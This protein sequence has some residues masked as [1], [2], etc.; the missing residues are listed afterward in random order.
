MKILHLIDPDSVVG[1]VETLAVIAD[2]IKRLPLH[3][4]DVLIIGNRQWVTKARRIGLKTIGSIS[5]ANGR[6]KIAHR[7]LRNVISCNENAYGKYDLLHAWS[8][9]CAVLAS[10]ATPSH[11]IVA[12]PLLGEP[13]NSKLSR[14]DIKRLNKSSARILC[15]T[16]KIKQH[17]VSIGIDQMMLSE[18]SPGID[19]DRITHENRKSLRESWNV[20]EN[21]FVVGLIGN[22]QAAIIATT[23][24][25]Q[26]KRDVKLIVHQDSQLRSQATKWLKRLGDENAMVVEN[27]FSQLWKIAPGLD[28]AVI[29]TPQAQSKDPYPQSNNLVSV[30]WLMAAGTPIIMDKSH[31]AS[32][33]ITQNNTGLLIPGS[34]INAIT[35]EILRLIDD[36]KFAQQIKSASKKFVADQFIANKLAENLADIYQQ[37]S[38]GQRVRINETD[39]DIKSPEN[40]KLAAD[41]AKNTSALLVKCS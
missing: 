40:V 7:A 16:S 2:A 20:N 32:S 39:A 30:L 27:D 35:T 10:N 41:S 22:T 37:A 36:P 29:T 6:T 31:A 24:V 23:R 5:P 34:S 11:Q 1:G 18:V 25:K 26:T 19:I 15:G 21:T 12:G 13:Q 38:R 3:S 9:D 4:H 28:A 8:I 33:Y 14:Q 17:C